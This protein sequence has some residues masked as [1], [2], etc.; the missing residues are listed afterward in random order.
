MGILNFGGLKEGNQNIPPDKI[1]SEF[2]DFYK[3]ELSLADIKADEKLGYARKYNYVGSFVDGYLNDEYALAKE[4]LTG[5][6]ETKYILIK[7]ETK[8]LNPRSYIYELIN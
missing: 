7:D 2:K 5:A 4:K 6:G 8:E 3:H 1:E